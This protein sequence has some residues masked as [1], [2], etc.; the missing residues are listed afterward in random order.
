MALVMGVREGIGSLPDIVTAPCAK[1]FQQ[2]IDIPSILFAEEA[3]NSHL[4]TRHVRPWRIA[5]RSKKELVPIPENDT[6]TVRP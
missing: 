3:K 2:G 1:Y 4:H 6:E 5:F